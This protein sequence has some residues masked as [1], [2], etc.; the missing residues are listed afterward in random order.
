MSRSPIPPSGPSRREWLASCAGALAAAG[1]AGCDT[2]RAQAAPKRRDDATTGEDALDAALAR[3]HGD[4]P[5]VRQGLSTHDPMA[6]EA[7]CVLGLSD[8]ALEWLDEHGAPRLHV[9]EPTRRITREDWRAALGPDWNAATWEAQIGRFGD[10]VLFFE[11]ELKEASWQETLDTWS[12]RLAPGLC[13]AATHGLIRTAH[14]ARAMARRDSPPRRA[15]LVRGLAYWAAAYQELPVR[16]AAT[17]ASDASRAG[18]SRVADGSA[19]AVPV[20]P[21]ATYRDA[22]SSLP[23]FVERRGAAPGGNIVNG[24]RQVGRL[25]GFDAARD[26]VTKREDVDAAL[27]ELTATFAR[28]YLR[29]GTRHHAIAFV[30]AVTAPCALRKLVPLLKPATSAAALPYAWQAAAGIYS[31]Y[32]GPERDSAPLDPEP[33]LDRAQLAAR[34]LDNGDVHAIK[35]TEALLAEDA[36]APDPAYRAAAEDAVLRL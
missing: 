7:L 17:P 29:H 26:L 5:R 27:S 18:S 22:L 9:P 30:H 13:G 34:A 25:E 11:E 3:I 6:I 23:R 2:S 33:A 8:H 1:L 32:V 10:W 35:F 15:E 36:L 24:L 21:V 28:V 19:A 4:E 20:S 31:A 16:A 12:A 14:A